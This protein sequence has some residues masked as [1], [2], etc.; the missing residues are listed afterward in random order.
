MITNGKCSGL[1]AFFSIWSGL[2]SRSGY[3]IPHRL[4]PRTRYFMTR[5]D[6]DGAHTMLAA[7]RVSSI[8]AGK[9]RFCLK[10][11]KIKGIPNAK[12]G[13]PKL[14]NW[15]ETIFHYGGADRQDPLDHK[16]C[17]RVY[18]LMRFYLWQVPCMYCRSAHFYRVGKRP[19]DFWRILWYG[20]QWAILMKIMLRYA[21][22][23]SFFHQV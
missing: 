14:L 18:G 5:W 21:D 3:V 15:I 7:D 17:Q 13:L 4:I 12:V 2:G 1:E 20:K 19:K 11:E 16:A 22:F 6:L 10:V 23:G 9:W 8:L